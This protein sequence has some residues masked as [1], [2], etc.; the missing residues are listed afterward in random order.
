MEHNFDCHHLGASEVEGMTHQ[1]MVYALGQQGAATNAIS[2][3]TGFPQA[4]SVRPSHYLT[5][6]DT[7]HPLSDRAHHLGARPQP[8][9]PNTGGA[10]SEYPFSCISE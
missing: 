2:R 10:Q 8:N 4:S 6:L 7:W 5:L 3:A 9:P 1:V